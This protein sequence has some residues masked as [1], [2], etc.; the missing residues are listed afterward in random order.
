[1]SHYRHILFSLY[2]FRPSQCLLDVHQITVFK[3][4]MALTP[5]LSLSMHGLSGKVWKGHLVCYQCIDW[6]INDIIIYIIINNISFIIGIYKWMCP[7]LQDLDPV[8]FGFDVIS[9]A[10]R[11]STGDTEHHPS[12]GCF[13]RLFL[14]KAQL[15]FRRPEKL[16]LCDM[17]LL[18]LML[19]QRVVA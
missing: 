11:Q 13:F 2:I 12:L 9:A 16:L 3:C 15:D 7:S 5:V 17:A 10:C 8:L 6:Y 4:A 19:E 14:A 1:M 18:L